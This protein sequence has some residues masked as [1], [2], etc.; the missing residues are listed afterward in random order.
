MAKNDLA[1]AA[2]RQAWSLQWDHFYLLASGSEVALQKLSASFL[3]GK[4]LDGIP[5]C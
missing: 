4:K 5:F 2:L 1:S 3:N